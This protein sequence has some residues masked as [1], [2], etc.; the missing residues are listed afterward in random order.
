MKAMENNLDMGETSKDF[1]I[2]D[3]VLLKEKLLSLEETIDALPVNNA[4]AGETY[5]GSF[6]FELLEKSKV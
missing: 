6:I 4:E 2:D 3:L 5:A 1:T